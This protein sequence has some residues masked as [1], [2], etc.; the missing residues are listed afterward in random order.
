MDPAHEPRVRRAERREQRVGPDGADEVE[1]EVRV[2][3]EQPE[4]VEEE[5]EP[6]L[7]ELEEGVQCEP[8]APEGVEEEEPVRILE[9][10]DPRPPPSPSDGSARVVW[11]VVLV[12]RSR[13]GHPSR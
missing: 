8:E 4:K 2:G 5:Q 12:V 9:V 7:C 13:V 10:E 1:G 6:R 11:G 3:T